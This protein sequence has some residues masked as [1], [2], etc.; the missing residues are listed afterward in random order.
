M[1]AKEHKR[2]LKFKVC[3]MC[4]EQN[5]ARLVELEPDFIG[6]IFHELSPRFC[7]R[8]PEVVIPEKITK[9]GV[10]VNKS[11]D[12]ILLR[13]DEFE[14]NMVQ[15]HGQ[16]S[17]EFCSKIEGNGLPVIKAF[18]ITPDFDFGKLKDYESSCTLFLFDAAGKNAG[19]NGTVFNWDLL[20]N[21]HGEK[22][23]LL[24]GGITPALA[25]EIKNFSHP[26]LYG[27]D[28]NS[29]FEIKPGIKNIAKIKAFKNELSA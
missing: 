16:E 14:L 29:G 24:S 8:L 27:I 20:Q 25:K 11:I 7:L 4:D 23:F 12:Y 17:P 5:I 19:G 22:P 13:S 21:Y 3:G 2:E 18:N 15:L 28:I 9:V 1:S 6:F 10:F 26:L